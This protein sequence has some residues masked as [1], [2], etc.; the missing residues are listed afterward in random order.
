M[1]PKSSDAPFAVYDK[2]DNLVTDYGGILDVMKDEFVHRLRNREINDE[3]FEL[4]QLKEYL[5][6]LR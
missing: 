1:F 5:C 2:S 3:Y 6:K 4:K